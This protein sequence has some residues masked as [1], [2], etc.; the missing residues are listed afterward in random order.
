MSVIRELNKPH[1]AIGS[2]V[3]CLHKT[4][5]AVTKSTQVDLVEDLR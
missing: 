5:L 3:I 2:V 1:E 4:N